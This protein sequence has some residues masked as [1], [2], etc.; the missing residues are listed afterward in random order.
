MNFYSFKY[1]LSFSATRQFSTKMHQR[2]V[3]IK[4]HSNIFE[5]LLHIL[6][7]FFSCTS[8]LIFRYVQIL[9]ISYKF[10]KNTQTKNPRIRLTPCIA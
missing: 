7:I 6:Q 1:I 9:Q 4:K 10:R 2:H 5:I 8:K 3:E